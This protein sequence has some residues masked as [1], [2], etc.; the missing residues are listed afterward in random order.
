MSLSGRLITVRTSKQ[1][2][3]MEISKFSQEYLDEIASLTINPKDL[4][5][6]RLNGDMKALLKTSVGEATVTC[7]PGDVPE[8]LFFLPLGALA[9]TLIGGESYGT[10]VP[11]FKG[12]DAL[13]SRPAPDNYKS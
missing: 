10:G 11:D 7:R 1:G 6:L 8:G 5:S 4:E 13:L 2:A 3:A 9:N 12:V